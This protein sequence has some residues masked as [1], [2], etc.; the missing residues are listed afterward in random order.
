[1]GGEMIKIHYRHK[2][3]YRY[4]LPRRL[5]LACNPSVYRWLWWVYGSPKQEVDQTIKAT[6][7]IPNLPDIGNRGKK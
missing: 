2:I 1:M 7:N 4:L 5:T 3:W 6:L